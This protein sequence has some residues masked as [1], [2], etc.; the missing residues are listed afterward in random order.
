M[1]KIIITA[2]VAL[3]TVAMAAPAN[4][5]NVSNIAGP[6]TTANNWQFSPG[7]VCLSN[8]AYVPVLSALVDYPNNC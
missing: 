8:G 1:R 7:A 5:D 3:A 2:A 6:V 4:A